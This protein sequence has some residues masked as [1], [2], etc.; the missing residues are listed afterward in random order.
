LAGSVEKPVGGRDDVSLV[1]AVQSFQPTEESLAAAVQPCQDPEESLADTLRSFVGEPVMSIES[2]VELAG[3]SSNLF[4]KWKG[5][6]PLFMSRSRAR[7]S[8]VCSEDGRTWLRAK[9][10][11]RLK[12]AGFESGARRQLTAVGW[13]FVMVVRVVRWVRALPRDSPGSTE[14]EMARPA[15]LQ[16]SNS[17]PTMDWVGRSVI[18]DKR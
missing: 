1:L 16:Q 10:S 17:T 11:A 2:V 8:T 6:G 12:E 14:T 9:V 13:H 18:A 3:V 7:W 4:N 5:T 15:M